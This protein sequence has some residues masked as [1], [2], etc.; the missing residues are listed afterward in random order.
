MPRSRAG[1]SI[2][3]WWRPSG[4]ARRPAAARAAQATEKRRDRASVDALSILGYLIDMTDV[5]SSEPGARVVE[6]I[7]QRIVH[8]FDPEQIILFG[9]RARGDAHSSSDIDLLVVMDYSG[10]RRLAE[11]RVSHA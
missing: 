3:A 6:A 10:S 7:T 2:S 9:S 11:T 8:D 5:T 1:T 4:R